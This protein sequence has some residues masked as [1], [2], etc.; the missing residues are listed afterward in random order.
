[1]TAARAV[2]VWLLL[3]AAIV[4]ALVLSA[5]ATIDL[6]TSHG[7][8][9]TIAP[10]AVA[11]IEIASLAGTLMWVLVAR[12]SLRRDAIAA[13]IA[14]TTVALVA[15]VHAYGWFG[16]VGAVALVIIVHLASRAWREDWSDTEPADDARATVA[17]L[18]ASRELHTEG[19]GSPRLAAPDV[20]GVEPGTVTAAVELLEREPAIGRPRMIT[21][22]G[23]TDHQARKLLATL[24]PMQVAS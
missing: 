18:V 10:A 4:G 12:W 14:A 21:E 5:S 13:T 17:D 16:A 7:V 1:M 6:A 11:M 9:A 24:R 3:P 20:P 15:G 23:V 22:L 2:I 19:E 8:P